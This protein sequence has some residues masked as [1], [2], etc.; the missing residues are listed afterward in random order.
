MGPNLKLRHA[1]ALALVGWYLMTPPP[2]FTTGFDWETHLRL[3]VRRGNYASAVECER[4]LNQLRDE[5]QFQKERDLQSAAEM[6]ANLDGRTIAQYKAV[7]LAK[8]VSTD[9]PRLK[10]K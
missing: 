7:R 2:A 1:A 8:C 4:A 9:D 3:W 5:T 10:S 6:D